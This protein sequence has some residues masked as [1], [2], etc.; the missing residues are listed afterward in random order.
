[1]INAASQRRLKPVDR[2]QLLRAC[3]TSRRANH[4]GRYKANEAEGA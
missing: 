4:F 3:R 1:M 2:G